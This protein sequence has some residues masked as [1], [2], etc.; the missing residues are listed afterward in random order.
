MN[1]FVNAQNSIKLDLSKKIYFDPYLISDRVNDADYIFITHSHYD[2]FSVEDIEKIIKSNTKL[3]V[4]ESMHNLVASFSNEILE[5]LP[6]NKYNID[7]IEFDTIS[8]YN[9]NKPYHKKE[10]NNVGYILNID[11]N[12]YYVAGDTDNILELQNIKCDYAFVPI[13]GTY[14]MDYLEA[15]ELINKIKPKCV[16]PTHYK[17]VV[18]SDED[19]IKFKEKISKDILVNILF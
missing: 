18:G 12:K 11:G 14:T 15:S 13:G 10:D 16:I 2:H 17:T 19:A 6:N 9:I 8:S 7:G 3:I 5:V 1:I 4:P